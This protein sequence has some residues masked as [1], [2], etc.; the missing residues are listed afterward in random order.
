MCCRRAFATATTLSD[1]RVLVV[2]G[3]AGQRSLTSTQVY[4][5]AR[6]RWL[7][8]GKLHASRGHQTATLL[9]SGRVLVVGGQRFNGPFLASSELYSP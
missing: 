1:G 9:S 3:F 8:A 7:S 4:D 2:A 6:R 5:P